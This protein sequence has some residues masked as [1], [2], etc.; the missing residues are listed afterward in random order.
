[1]IFIAEHFFP[2]FRKEKVI[3]ADVPVPYSVVRSCDRE[4]VLLFD[5]AKLSFGGFPVRNI[6]CRSINKIAA[7]VRTPFDKF[8]RPVFASVP[9]DEIQNL[10]L[11]AQF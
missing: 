3:R 10:L 5:V 6:P 8:I 4:F 9:V 11:R 2:S 1:M 7:R